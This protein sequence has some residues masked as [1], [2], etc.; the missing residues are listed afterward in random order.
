MSQ[1]LE[2][3]NV[4]EEKPQLEVL[5]REGGPKSSV[6]GS[7]PPGHNQLANALRTVS[8]LLVGLWSEPRMVREVGP[9]QRPLERHEF[10]NPANRNFRGPGSSIV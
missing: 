9:N 5:E 10:E 4:I 6:D 2:K 3:L 8:L 7:S 1:R